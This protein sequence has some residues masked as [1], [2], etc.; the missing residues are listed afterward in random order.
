MRRFLSCSAICLLLP[1][2]VAAQGL[3]FKAYKTQEE[4]CLDNPKAPTCSNGKPFKM[5][6]LNKGLKAQP[7]VVLNLHNQGSSGPTVLTLPQAQP[8]RPAEKP[9][10]LQADWRFAH[11]RAEL[12]AGVDVAALRES[13]TVRDLLAKLTGALQISPADLDRVRVHGGGIDQAWLSIRSDDCLLLLQG[14]LELPAGFVKLPNGMSSYRI[15]NTAAVLGREKSVIAAVQR[16]KTRT[17]AQPPAMQEIRQLSAGNQLW[18]IGSASLL[19]E[20]LQQ[21]Q[22]GSPGKTAAGAPG[23]PAAAQALDAVLKASEI[24]GF[25]VGMQLQDGFRMD[26]LLKFASPAAARRMLASGG[27]KGISS[28]SLATSP[29]NGG[30][31]K[32][33]SRVENA[34][35]RVTLSVEQAELMRLL[36]KALASPAGQKLQATAAAARK[37]STVTVYG[38]DGARQLDGS[39]GVIPLPNNSPRTMNGIT[40]QGGSQRSSAL[41]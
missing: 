26:A 41:K 37:P 33:S 15:S 32:L 40:I 31:V 16:L 21:A 20:A 23:T 8:R 3:G 28:S 7:P 6:D 39:S 19:K 1:A 18:F 13:Q 34:S 4:Y 35:A 22:S 14:R 2:V 9:L 17:S 29:I 5:Q 12:L 11:P 36:D 38:Q 10:Q 30:A 24:T 27:A 25:S